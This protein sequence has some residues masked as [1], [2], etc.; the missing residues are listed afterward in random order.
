MAGIIKAD[1]WSDT[2]SSS[3]SNSVAFNFEDISAKASDYLSVA[4]QQAQQIVAAAEQEAAQIRQQA[5]EQG[6][7]QALVE[8]QELV[9]E[10]LDEQLAT[11]VPA[12]Q[13]AVDDLR[14]SKAEWL[15]H[16]EQRTVG[17]AAAISERV[18]RRELQQ[19]PEI[20]LELVREALELSMGTGDVT[21][22]LHPEDYDTMRDQTL[23]ITSQLASVGS[24]T[25][26]PTSDVSRGGCRVVTEFGVVDQTIEAQLERIAE[27]LG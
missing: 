17:L 3:S 14:H 13:A 9:G 25:I 26:V 27:E 5:Q 24:A 16:W 20:T 19:S 10:T 7:Q 18:I 2:P 12:L 23:A 1:R 15:R 8:A 21:I 11:L 22:Q 4:Q 6:R